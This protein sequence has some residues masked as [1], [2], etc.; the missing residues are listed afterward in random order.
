MVKWFPSACLT[1]LFLGSLS[2]IMGC[3]S[4]QVVMP[5]PLPTTAVHVATVAIPT[6]TLRLLET[7]TVATAAAE[8]SETIPTTSLPPTPEPV[9][10][11]LADSGWIPLQTG[12][13]KRLINLYDE[14]SGSL[15]ETIYLLRLDPAH[16]RFDVGYEAGNSKLLAA[17]QEESGAMVV[18]NGGFFT[19]EQIATALVITNGSA[20]GESYVGF[21]G[22]IGLAEEQLTIQDLA[23]N[24][25]TGSEGYQA[26]MQSFPMLVLP[27]GQIGF[28]ADKESGRRARR[29]VIAQDRD[30]AVL[31]LIT[32]RGGFTLHQ[33]SRYLVESDLN[34]DV[35]LNL[36][37]GPSS[38]ILLTQAGTVEGFGAYTGIPLVLLVYPK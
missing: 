24:R 30:G 9:I 32:P 25:Y 20:Q 17:W 33:L 18:V 12:L 27:G 1:L 13:E 14:T 35:A 11:P 29:T 28:P 34:L 38:G 5:E 10:T 31:L 37:G 36:D 2:L 21:G 7:A 6:P 4:P 22:M 19:A 16:F 26:G 15:W 8:P 23:R 3:Q